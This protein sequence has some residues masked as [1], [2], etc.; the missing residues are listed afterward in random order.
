MRQPLLLW[1]GGARRLPPLSLKKDRAVLSAVLGNLAD[2]R[3]EDEAR[4]VVITDQ[5]LL[6]RLPSNCPRGV[7]GER[8]PS[9]IID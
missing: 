8:G 3:Y 4:D 7:T 5:V 1:L 9:R 2:L 6:D